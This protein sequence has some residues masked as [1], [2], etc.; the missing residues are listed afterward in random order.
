[1]LKMEDP[2]LV[3]HRKWAKEK[4]LLQEKEEIT[5]EQIPWEGMG[6]RN[7][8]EGLDFDKKGSIPS[9]DEERER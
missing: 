3:W 7:H 5:K 4:Y 2:V 6:A 1:M 9:V 8:V